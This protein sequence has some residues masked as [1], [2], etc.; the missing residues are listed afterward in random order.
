[1]LPVPDVSIDTVVKPENGNLSYI[2]K[3]LEEQEI[4]SLP[5]RRT[6]RF[7]C[8][9]S[10]EVNW[11]RKAW[12]PITGKKSAVDHLHACLGGQVVTKITLKLDAIRSL[13]IAAKVCVFKP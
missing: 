10:F 12:D 3:V 2:H 13:F 4:Y 8:S 7:P 9:S 1:M 11:N 5:T 6:G